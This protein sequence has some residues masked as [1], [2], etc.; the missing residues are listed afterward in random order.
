PPSRWRRPSSRS[1]TSTSRRWGSCSDERSPPIPSPIPTAPGRPTT[2][3]ASSPGRAAQI[4]A[5]GQRPPRTMSP[6]LTAPPR[7]VPQRPGSQPRLGYRPALD[8]VR[9]LAVVA[10]FAYHANLRWARAGF[11]GVDLFFV[12]RGYFIT[13]LL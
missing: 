4:V 3:S 13:D 10:V 2:P 9:T 5:S 11:L 7:A 6:V 12:L 1:R 8:G